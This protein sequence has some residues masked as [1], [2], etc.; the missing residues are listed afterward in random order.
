MSRMLI[1]PRHIVWS[2]AELD[3]ERDWKDLLSDQYPD[4]TEDELV[5][6][7]Y[8]LNNA[9]LDDERVNLNITLSRPILVIADLGLWYG[10]RSGYAEIRSGNIRDC[11]YTNSDY[12][13]WFVD[14][15][16]D[17]RCD[18]I[19]HDDTNH[20]LYRVYKDTAT[21]AQI[22]RLQEKLYEGTATRQDITRL[23]MRL[24]DAIADVY[25]W[26]IKRRRVA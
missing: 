8:D 16:G 4:H 25:G 6:L 21:E 26:R 17:L 14:A 5:S 19:H 7:M 23:T 11:L 22:S 9:Y 24:G 15:L 18:A 3:F 10:R 20:L 2:N 12:A 13:T 1:K